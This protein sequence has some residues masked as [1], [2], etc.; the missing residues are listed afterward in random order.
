MRRFTVYTCPTCGENLLVDFEDSVRYCVDHGPI[1]SY[2]I[3]E[4]EAV[5]PEEFEQYKEQVE[6]LAAARD[7][8]GRL[9]DMNKQ[10]LDMNREMLARIEELSGRPDEEK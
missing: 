1:E 3:V 10:L 4:L 5:I 2:D 8:E 9:V 7:L 6:S